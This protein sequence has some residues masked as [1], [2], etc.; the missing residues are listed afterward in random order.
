MFP[1]GGPGL[2]LLLLRISVAAI[3]TL[4]AASSFGLSSR[5]SWLVV[6]LTVLISISLCVG[7]LTPFLSVIAF[8]AAALNLLLGAQ[9]GNLFNTS[10]L[11]AAA[12]LVFLGPGAYSVDAKLFGLRI[13]VFPSR[14]NTNPPQLCI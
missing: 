3:F 7:F 13:T 2:G 8:V 5:L 14:K 4:N 10:I 6:S 1:R 9:T 12:A 11:T